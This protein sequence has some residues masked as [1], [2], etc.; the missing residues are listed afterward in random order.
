M[1]AVA[2]PSIPLVV[3]EEALV[4]APRKTAMAW[5]E[6]TTKGTA[7]GTT[8]PQ[9]VRQR[10]WPW[11]GI[12]PT[13]IHTRTVTLEGARSLAPTP[14]TTQL[15]IRLTLAKSACPQSTEE[16]CTASPPT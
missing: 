3:V 11:R 12:T 8:T 13:H 6:T 16:R 2:C 4:T 15:S 14:A 9:E 10:L 7:M 1:S 5:V